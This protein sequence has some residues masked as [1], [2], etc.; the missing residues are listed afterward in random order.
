[1]SLYDLVSIGDLA[2]RWTYTREGI[3]RLAKRDPHFPKSVTVSPTRGTRLWRLT[4][5]ESYERS[6]PWLTNED[7]KRRQRRL[8]LKRIAAGSRHPRGR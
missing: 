7:E 8:L 1:M 2:Q 3:W 6:R 5:I 4:D